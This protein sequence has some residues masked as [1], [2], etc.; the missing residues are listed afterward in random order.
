MICGGILTLQ[1]YSTVEFPLGEISGSK[2]FRQLFTSPTKIAS[3]QIFPDIYSQV[4][5]IASCY[6]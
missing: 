6:V 4:D 5:I 3:D 1:K 2:V